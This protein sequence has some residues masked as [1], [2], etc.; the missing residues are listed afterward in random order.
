MPRPRRNEKIRT[1]NILPNEALNQLAL[2]GIWYCGNNARFE[3]SVLRIEQLAE[4]ELEAVR[5]Y[6]DENINLLIHKT[7]ER[8]DFVVGA[9]PFAHYAFASHPTDLKS[10]RADYEL[11][12]ETE[13]NMREAAIEKTLTEEFEAE[14]KDEEK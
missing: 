10:A 3:G 5:D 7:R 13:G 6:W 9:M 2:W 11:Q 4:D 1:R 14:E 12:D 8:Y